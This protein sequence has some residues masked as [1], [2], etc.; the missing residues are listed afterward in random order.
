VTATFQLDLL[1]DRHLSIQERFERFDRE[2]PHVYPHLRRLALEARDAGLQR[3]GV[4]MLWE[5][6]RWHVAI[7]TRDPSGLKLN[8]HYTSRYVR[9]LIREH[10]E[11]DGLFETR[12][13]RA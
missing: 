6:M 9:K 1:A 13:L 7:E 4:R 5:V 12:R 2:N 8:D 3:I 10:P 11:L